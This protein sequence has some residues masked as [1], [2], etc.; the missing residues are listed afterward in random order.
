MDNKSELLLN[1]LAIIAEEESI[2]IG[3]NMRWAYER[4]NAVGDPFHKAPYGY[5]R[6]KKAN[7]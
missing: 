3:Q 1:V 4:R 2:S 5:R 6:D 7:R